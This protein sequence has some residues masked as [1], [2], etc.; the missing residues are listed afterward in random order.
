M[1]V[2]DKHVF[3]ATFENKP[4]EVPAP[5]F[6]EGVVARFR[7]QF[8]VD[9]LLA[10][11]STDHWREPLVLELL[12]ARLALVDADGQP[13]VDPNDDA[14]YQQGAEFPAHAGMN[15]RWAGTRCRSTRSSPHTRG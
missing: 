11:A 3:A 10:V 13:V 9:D 6:G 8:T 7:A 12:L 14:W 1:Q 15:R 4:I 5:E 2:A